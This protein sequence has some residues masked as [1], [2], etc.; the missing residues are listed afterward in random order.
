MENL[1]PVPGATKDTSLC[2]NGRM[3]RRIYTGANLLLY[4]RDSQIALLISRFIKRL[5]P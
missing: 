2:I 5:F 1:Q 4:K 3:L